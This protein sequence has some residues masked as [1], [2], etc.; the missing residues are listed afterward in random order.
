MDVLHSSS[1]SLAGYQDPLHWV[2]FHFSTY[3]TDMLAETPCN[4]STTQARYQPLAPQKSVKQNWTSISHHTI[5]TL[6]ESSILTELLKNQLNKCTAHQCRVSAATNISNKGPSQLQ[7]PDNIK[8]I[9]LFLH[10]NIH[11]DENCISKQHEKNNRYPSNLQCKMTVTRR[12]NLISASDK[13]QHSNWLLG[14]MNRSTPH[15]QETSSHKTVTS[16]TTL[17]TSTQISKLPSI[18]QK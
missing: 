6:T 8:I 15:L 16:L 5:L 4:F 1:S 10:T 12:I 17:Q 18:N 14:F 11:Q 9:K 3:H 7:I 13:Q 2:C